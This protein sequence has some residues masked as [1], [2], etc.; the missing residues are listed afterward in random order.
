MRSPTRWLAF[1]PALALLGCGGRSSVTDASFKDVPGPG[2]R[3]GPLDALVDRRV[4]TRRQDVPVQRD[5]VTWPD[6][7]RKDKWP[8]PADGYSS[9]GS[10]FGCQVDSDCFGVKCCPTPWGVHLCATDCD[11]LP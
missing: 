5:K 6:V 9:G 10:P 3:D 1:L 8:W 11:H 4:E 2:R 7:T